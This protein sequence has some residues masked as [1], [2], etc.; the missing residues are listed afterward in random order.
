MAINN[1]FKKWAMS[2]KDWKAALQRFAIEF[3]GRFPT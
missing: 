1:I 3:E 2:I